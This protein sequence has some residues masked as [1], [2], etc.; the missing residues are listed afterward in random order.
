MTPIL[1]VDKVQHMQNIEKIRKES[2][3]ER[4]KADVKVMLLKELND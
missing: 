4:I 1:I 2:K 3:D